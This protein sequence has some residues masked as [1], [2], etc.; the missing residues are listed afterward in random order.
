MTT[1]KTLLVLGIIACSLSQAS[2]AQD[3][4]RLSAL[5]YYIAASAQLDVGNIVQMRGASNLPPGA[6]IALDIVAPNG[7][8][9]TEYSKT[10]CVTTSEEGLFNQEINVL[11]GLPNR[12]DLF[13]RATFLTNTCNQSAQVLQVVGRHGEFLGN[14][15]HHPTMQE[16]EMA[17]THGMAKN[18]QLFQVSGSYFGI[19][20]FA[21][22]D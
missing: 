10:V 22:V 16:V 9:W 18:P 17:W 2:R 7:A 21:R 13:V 15:A 1:R 6:S 19:A 8:G 3:S 5:G 14:D 12:S 20:T 4:R 11:S